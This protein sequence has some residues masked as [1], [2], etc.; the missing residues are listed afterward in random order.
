M[1][2]TTLKYTLLAIADHIFS[3]SSTD[4][5]ETALER[6][7]AGDSVTLQPHCPADLDDYDTILPKIKRAFRPKSFVR[8]TKKATN[9]EHDHLIEMVQINVPITMDLTK[10]SAKE[11]MI[12]LQNLDMP[13][14][15]TCHQPKRSNTEFSCIAKIGI[16][17]AFF[18]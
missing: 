18:T 8:K 14:L 15:M 9:P 12:L 7:C 10:L 13:V 6:F 4:V 5:L 11:K 2:R 17:M 16:Q 1:D 3:T